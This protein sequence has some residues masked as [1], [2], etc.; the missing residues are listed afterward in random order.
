MKHILLC[1]AAGLIIACKTGG[2]DRHTDPLA[3]NEP[4]LSVVSIEPRPVLE[5][6]ASGS[7]DEHDV[8]NPSVI[9]YGHELY[10][11]YSG[12]GNSVWST[13]LAV[14]QDNGLT[15]TK[16][17]KP[18]LIP[19]QPSTSIPEPIAANGSTIILGSKVFHY[20]V[21]TRSDT[22]N[23]AVIKLATSQ[24]GQSFDVLVGE[25]FG[26][27]GVS[28]AFDATQV[29]DPYVIQ[30]GGTLYLYYTGAPEGPFR[31]LL[32]VATSKDGIHWARSASNPL[33]PQGAPGM[34]DEFIQGEP[35]V[36]NTGKHWYMLYVGDTNRG[37]RSLGWA[38]SSNGIHWE[39]QS[40]K[41]SIVPP[42]LRQPWF[43]TMMIDP[44]IVPTGA[45]NG[46]Y[47]VYFGGGVRPGNQM[48]DG[49]IGRLV[50]KLDRGVGSRH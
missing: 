48:I 5:P 2:A 30:V 14:S 6:G 12:Y 32:G 15:W 31:V 26:P 16:R 46:T 13:G 50:I 49:K 35:A 4:R 42:R 21:D 17:T 1:F 9:R 37:D 40:T 7:W 47:F 25:V 19:K 3:G 33:L 45:G 8:L 18:L 28:G 41:E 22:E 23:I 27:S 11:Y 29:A 38:S 44:D 34:F 10:N 36:V 20:Y 24:D 39:R 43:A